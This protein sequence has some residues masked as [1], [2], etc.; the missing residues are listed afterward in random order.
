[1]TKQEILNNASRIYIELEEYIKNLCQS[2][3]E[4]DKEKSILDSLDVTLQVMLLYLS[5]SNFKVPDIE[6]DFI[7]LLTTEKDIITL[8][9]KEMNKNYSWDSL[10]E[11]N[12][13]VEEVKEFIDRTYLLF[14]PDIDLLV[15]FLAS[16]DSKTEKNELEYIESKLRE[17]LV[18]F[19]NLSSDYNLKYVD[20]I[21]NEIFVK[22]Y[23]SLVSLFKGIDFKL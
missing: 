16:N 13:E 6:L 20:L 18:L 1:M 5:V 7:R 17:I 10:R 14:K 21:L 22:K 2:V 4:K 11:E 15:G 23:K 9:N 19:T 12:M 3:N 8:Y